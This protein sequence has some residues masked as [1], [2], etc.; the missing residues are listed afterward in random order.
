[1]DHVP[2]RRFVN[3]FEVLGIS[4]TNNRFLFGFTIN[5]I[6]ITILLFFIQRDSLLYSPNDFA[7]VDEFNDAFQLIITFSTVLSLLF[8]TIH[9]KSTFKE[10]FAVVS[11]LDLTFRDLRID[12]QRFYSRMAV[13]YGR[14][15]L[16]LLC[17]TI[18][19][20]AF[21]ILNI[22]KSDHDWSLYWMVN[23]LPLMLNRFRHL[24][25]SFMLRILVLQ[26]EMI[27]MTLRKLVEVSRNP[28]LFP[29]NEKL[30]CGVQRRLGALRR[31]FN[32]I[33]E[34]FKAFN[35]MF[36]YSLVINLFQNFIELLSGSYWLYFYAFK[37]EWVVSG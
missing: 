8:E 26:L 23:I 24:Q 11:K 5:L 17:G 15:F 9:R 34:E 21:I 2:L 18:G 28:V 29:Q 30:R 14:E 12:P 13:K 22:V 7:F 20:E 31:A 6:A 35:R 27:E 1:M 3:F 25:Y 33:L 19:L 32:L 10:F 4:P 37:N 16:L 36:S